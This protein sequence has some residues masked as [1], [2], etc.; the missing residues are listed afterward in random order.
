MSLLKKYIRKEIKGI[1]HEKTMRIPQILKT[2]LE[3][4]LELSPTG[5]YIKD[6]KYPISSPPSYEITLANDE[7]FD[8]VFQ[9]GPEPTFIVNISSNSYDLLNTEEKNLARQE[10]NSLLTG[11]KFSL[12]G[13]EEV[14]DE[15]DCGGETGG[16]GGGF[17]TG[18]D[19]ETEIE[20]GEEEEV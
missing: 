3:D 12:T 8:M 4:N 17:E 6:I 19:E 9:P 11:E 2:F 18:G 20:P 5:H 16:G 7:I 10:V 13:D 14:G 1:L 15:E